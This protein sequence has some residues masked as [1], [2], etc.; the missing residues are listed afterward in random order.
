MGGE[1]KLAELYREVILAN[2]ADPCGHGVD[3][4]ATHRAEGNNPLC[5][6]VVDLRLRVV[7]GVIEAAAFHGESC[8]ICTAAASLLCRHLPGQGVA[9]AGETRRAF[10]GAIESGDAA[11][12]P[13]Y[14]GA[15]L[16]V[17]AYPARTQC[18]LLPWE[19]VVEALER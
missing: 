17:R 3:I 13:D 5:G 2:A 4:E 12:C 7:D 10:E 14:L 16:G 11:A 15:M 6:D 1:T 8:A 19:T 9:A 18:A